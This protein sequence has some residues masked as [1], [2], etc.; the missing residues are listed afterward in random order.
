VRASL[1]PVLPEQLHDVG[2]VSRDAGPEIRLT[3]SEPELPHP[4][5]SKVACG[6]FQQHALDALASMLG[7][8]DEG[9]DIGAVLTVPACGSKT[10][11][12]SI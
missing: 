5:G 10:S 8:Y 7:E 11:K 3:A 12:R 9:Q 4:K 6:R 1:P 2:L